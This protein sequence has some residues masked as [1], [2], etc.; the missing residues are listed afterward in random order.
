M[1]TVS[2]FHK[3]INSVTSINFKGIKGAH[4]PMPE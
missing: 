1:H 3:I 2:H 4:V